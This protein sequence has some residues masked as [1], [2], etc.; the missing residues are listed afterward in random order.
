MAEEL[1]SLEVFVFTVF[2]R[3]PVSVAA[4]VVEVEHGRNG[5]YAETVNM[6]VFYPVEGVGN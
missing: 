5:I 4:A 6:E 3:N 1:D 2:I